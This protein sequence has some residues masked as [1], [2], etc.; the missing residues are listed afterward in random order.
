M[1]QKVK[2]MDFITFIFGFL[3]GMFFDYLIAFFASRKKLDTA[4]KEAKVLTDFYIKNNK[5]K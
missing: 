1:A 2:I 4:I 5:I 3:V